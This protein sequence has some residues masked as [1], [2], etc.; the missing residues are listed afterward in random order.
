M[1]KLQHDA[2]LSK[3][4]KTIC[5]PGKGILAADEST[6]TIGKRFEAIKLENNETNRRKYRQLLF[7]VS[8]EAHKYIGGVILYDETVHQ[9]DDHNVPFLKLMIDN[10]IVPGIKLDNGLVN[11][12]GSNDQV[13]WGLDGLSK[14]V[15]TYFDLGFRFSKWRAAYSISS[16]GQPSDLCVELNASYLASYA[17]ICQHG[18]L[19]P[20]V[21]PEVLV[22]E[23]G[24]NLQK[25]YDVTQRVLHETFVHLWKHN[26][27][28]EKMILKPNMI[29]SGEKSGEKVSHKD[30]ATATV[31]VLKKTVPSAVPGVLFLSGGQTEEESAIHLDEMN[32]IGKLPWHLSF[33]YGRAL[34]QSCIQK[35]NGEDKNIKDAQA[36]YL[37]KAL[38]CS[39]ASMGKLK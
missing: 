16:N 30:V 31:S 15:Q 38:N 36:V 1:S 34:Q 9:K 11:L 10:G 14:R 6:G 25:S 37:Q 2:E 39:L 7:S 33:S 21:E 26:V 8:E 29:L 24:H 27:D 4:I 5:T 22:T 35:W 19:V 13:A 20:I 18:G 28:L 3:A 17:S 23:G 12:P 32:K